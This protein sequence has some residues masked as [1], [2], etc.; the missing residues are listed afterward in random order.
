MIAAAVT[1]VFVTYGLAEAAI[2]AVATLDH[3][4]LDLGLVEFCRARQLPLWGFSAQTLS[5]V[6]VPHPTAIAT[7]T[8]GTPSVAEAAAILAY[9]KGTQGLLAA[10][11]PLLVPKQIF[12]LPNRPG[13]VT[14]AVAG[15]PP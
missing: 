11:R 9:Q 6:I 13:A 5:G 2:A 3:K 10:S 8:V 12:R 7:S 4:A 14:L 15:D 1:Q